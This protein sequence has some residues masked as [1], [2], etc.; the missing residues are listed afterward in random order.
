M[1]T[2]ADFATIESMLDEVFTPI[3]ITYVSPDGEETAVSAT[4]SAE[5]TD[6]QG[7]LG[8]ATRVRKMNVRLSVSDLSEVNQNGK[9][10]I[11]SVDWA[12][13]R[14]VLQ[15]SS[16][17]VLELIRHELVEHTRPGYRRQ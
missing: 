6:L 1:T 15:N 11:S 13:E 17:I 3:S 5:F 10:V 16:H 7:R 14:T 9:F 2:D 8:I 12:I 4:L